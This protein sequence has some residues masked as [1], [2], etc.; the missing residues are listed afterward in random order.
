VTKN[1]V[2]LD[3]EGTKKLN[4]FKE[5]EKQQMIDHL[6]NL[7]KLIEDGKQTIECRYE[8]SARDRKGDQVGTIKVFVA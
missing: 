2:V 5:R 6:K 1:I 8:Y 7:A 4:E 3:N